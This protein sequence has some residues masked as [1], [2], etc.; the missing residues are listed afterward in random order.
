M[1]IYR[2][3]SRTIT[4]QSL[5][6]SGAPNTTTLSTQYSIDGAAFANTSNS[7]VHVSSGCW[8]L[9]LSAS[10]MNGDVVT[11]LGTASGCVPAQ[12]EIYT[13]SDWTASRALKQDN[14]DATVSSRSIYGGAD[15]TGTTTLLSRLTAPRATN[16][17]N[18]DAAVSSRSTY[19]G[20]D[21]AGITTLLSRLTA[22]RATNLDNIDAAVS[23]RSTYAGIG[24][25]GYHD[26][27][28]LAI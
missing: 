2:N 14:L 16:L 12:R 26:H 3:Q 19:A 8:R 23:S 13:E 6:T 28:P 4:L 1:P 11:I 17:D 22:P 9:A 25:R 15:T 10:E 5:T 27:A 24:H 18:I 20:A 21:T 7:P